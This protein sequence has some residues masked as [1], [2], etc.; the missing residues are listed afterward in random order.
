[1]KRKTVYKWMG[2][3]AGLT[4]VLFATIYFFFIDN[5]VNKVTDTAKGGQPSFSFFVQGDFES[6]LDKPMDVSK[7]GE[8]LYV[9]DTNHKQVQVFDSSGNS[10]FKFG[11]EGEGEGKFKFPYG[12]AGDKAGNIYVAD[13][14]NGKISIF[15]KKGEFIK[16]F[17]ENSETPSISSPAGLRIFDKKLY[18]TDIEA[19]KVFVFNLEGK[20]LFEIVV[21]SN[22]QDR[23]NAPNAVTVD[24]DENIYVADSGNQRVVVYNKEGKFTRI[25]N[26]TKDGKGQS[27]FVNPRG[28]AVDSK[29]TLFMVDNMTH[30]VHAFDS[31]GKQISQFGG[32]GGENDQFYLPNGLF[33]DEKS[34]LYITDTFN[35][36]IAVYY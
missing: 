32:L 16:Y 33:V 1:M 19:Q 2:A 3:I 15:S 5:G 20:K 30:F 6:P 27:K 13:L 23:L 11:K 26:G 21:A 12:I 22:D 17:V 34:Q 10:V 24:D 18:V 7:I 25:I 8:Y 29:G 9:T 14:Y 35:Q 28:L 31:K 36:R 4:I